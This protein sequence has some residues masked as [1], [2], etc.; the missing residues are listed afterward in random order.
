[1]FG[2]LTLRVRGAES[3]ELLARETNA[4]LLQSFKY[5]RFCEHVE[6]N[7]LSIWNELA[8]CRAWTMAACK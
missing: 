7:S 3:L 1:M 4:A 6:T 5:H 2:P 8:N